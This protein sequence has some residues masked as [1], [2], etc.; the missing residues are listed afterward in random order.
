M[1]LNKEFQSLSDHL[2]IAMPSL[3]DPNFARSVTYVCE[4]NEEGAMGIVI[5]R[6]SQLTVHQ[7]LEHLDMEIHTNLHHPLMTGGPVQ[8][9]RGFVMHPSGHTWRSTWAI[10]R[11]ISVTT[12]Q[13]I[14]EDIANGKG[15]QN[16]LIAL[17]YAGWESGQL[18]QELL[19]NTWLTV[20]ADARILFDTPIEKRWP[21]A[22]RLI[23]FDITQLTDVA[24]H[25]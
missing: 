16:A 15:P 2:L 13:D 11:A 24:G 12:S 14:L 4:H 3:E 8:V 5:N 17:G 9:D 1:S 18:E 22:M 19:D 10:S 7:L 23:G 21:E 20:S 6:P 25:A